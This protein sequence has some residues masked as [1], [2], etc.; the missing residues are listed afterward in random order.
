[1]L[2]L[3]L[4]RAVRKYEQKNLKVS[5]LDGHVSILKLNGFYFP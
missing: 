5:S 4:W 1:M 3:L 2:V